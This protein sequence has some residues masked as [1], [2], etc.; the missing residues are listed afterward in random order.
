MWRARKDI[1]GFEIIYSEFIR[2]A[3]K[4]RRFVIEKTFSVTSLLPIPFQRVEFLT[5]LKQLC[6]KY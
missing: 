1:Q 4:G 5:N 2:E 3:K 6:S